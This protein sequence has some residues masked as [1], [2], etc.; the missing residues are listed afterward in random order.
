[1]I[2]ERL[3]ES[4]HGVIKDYRNHDDIFL[5]V[6]D[7][8]DWADQFD[9]NALLVLNEL[10][11][12]L[13]ETYISK[14][15][16]KILLENDLDYYQNKF[17]YASIEEF[18]KNTKFL[19]IQEPLKSQSVILKLI[20]EIITD[21][22]GLSFFNFEEYP[23]K[24]YIYFDDVLASGSTIGRDIVDFLN[25]KGNANEEHY[26]ELEKSNITL[27][28]CLFCLHLWGWEFQKY[29]IEK[30]FNA[31][32]KNKINWR[33]NYE[34]QNHGG[35]LNQRLNVVKP[36][37]GVNK[38]IN[39]YLENLN[40]AAKYE[41]YAYRKHNEPSQETF[42]TSALNR[43]AYEDV[44]IEKG[45]DILNMIKGPVHP[46]LRPLGIINPTYKV[47]GLGT[48]FFTWRNIP[49]N[50]PLVFWWGATGHS[51]KPLFPVFNRGK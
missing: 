41:S 29:R 38:Q 25:Q 18:L 9:E 31:N 48:H 39:S 43:A 37:K 23:K 5:S 6:N 34:V 2:K 30:T 16:A 46:S 15:K 27:S 19:N 21:K 51:W 49:N 24:H 11:H 26:K 42:F 14:Q 20:N 12:I 50:C 36:I 10:N 45:I 1:M 33:Y 44:L 8:I 40:K 28:V 35:F 3:A 22:T 4:I 13:P 32:V 7:I 17:K 47:F